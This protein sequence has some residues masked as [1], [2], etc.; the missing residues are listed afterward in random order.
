MIKVY[1]FKGSGQGAMDI[2][3][4]LETVQDFVGGQIDVYSVTDDLDLVLNGEGLINGLDVRAV[5]L[6]EGEIINER[7]IRAVIQGDCFVCR[8]NEK[9]DFVSIE[10]GDIETIRH[11]V[12]SV[13]PVCDGVIAIV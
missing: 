10:D 13:M 7:N 6:G 9:G 5:V 12:K 11:Y 3:D 8:H 1:G 4:S 2:E